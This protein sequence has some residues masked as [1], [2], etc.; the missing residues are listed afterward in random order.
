MSELIANALEKV[1]ETLAPKRLILGEQRRAMLERYLATLLEWNARANLVSRKSIDEGLGQIIAEC[2]HPVIVLP[3]VLAGSVL[4]LGSGAGLPGI[5]LKIWK[6]EISLTLVESVRKKALFLRRVV[7][8]LDLRDVTVINER[9]ENLPADLRGKFNLV[10]SRAMGPLTLTYPLSVLFLKP[11][12]SYVCYKTQQYRREL[13]RLEKEIG[14]DHVLPHKVFQDP[15]L[16][17][18]LLIFRNPK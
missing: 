6:P 18:T 2:F 16:R 3:E 17:G 5:I 14:L 11:G 15:G 1:N 8:S 12:G 7:E 4:D 13:A 10:T 9:A